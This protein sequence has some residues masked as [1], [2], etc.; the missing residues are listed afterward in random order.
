MITFFGGASL[1]IFALCVAG[2]VLHH[3]VMK[4]RWRVDAAF[5]RLEE[6]Q[7]AEQDAIEAAATTPEMPFTPEDEIAAAEEFEAAQADYAAYVSRFPG[8]V[9]KVVLNLP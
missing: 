5:D 8:N 3:L 6:L 1:V 4:K 7:L 2:L 9:L